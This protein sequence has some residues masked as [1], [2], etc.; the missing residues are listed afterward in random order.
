MDAGSGFP[1][2]SGRGCRSGGGEVALVFE[3]PEPVDAVEGRDLVAF[4]ERRVIEHGV[5]EVVDRSAERQHRLADV[6]QLA[7]TLADNVDAEQLA[8]L[9]MKD[10]LQEPGNVAEDLAAGDLLVARLA[11]LIRRG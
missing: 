2:L 3:D 4:R 7:G 9:A 5:D 1:L 11:D 8:G 6:D 10:Q